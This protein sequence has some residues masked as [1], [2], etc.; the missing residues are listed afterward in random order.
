MTDPVTSVEILCEAVV[1][2]VC[3]GLPGAVDVRSISPLQES[4]DVDALHGLF[5]GEPTDCTVSFRYAGC[6]VTVSG[7]DAVEVTPLLGTERARD[8]AGRTAGD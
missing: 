3:D 6:S 7:A 5:S 8:E 2:A 4:V 1:F